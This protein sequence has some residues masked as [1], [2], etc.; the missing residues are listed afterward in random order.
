[1]NS[2]DQLVMIDMGTN[3]GNPGIPAPGAVLLAGIG[4]GLVGWLRRRRTL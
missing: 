2:Q 1:V 3:D 4:V